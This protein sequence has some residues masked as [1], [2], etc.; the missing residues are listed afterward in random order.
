MNDWDL[1]MIYWWWMIEIYWWFI[2]D[3]WLRF[4]IRFI[5][6]EWL[7]LLMINDWDVP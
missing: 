7:R 1:L 5:D 4:S 3:E 2:D 6:D